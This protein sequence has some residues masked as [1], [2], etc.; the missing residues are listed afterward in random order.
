VLLLLRELLRAAPK[1]DRRHL[2]PPPLAWRLGWPLVCLLSL[3]V[4]PLMSAR[5]RHQWQQRLI[6]A[7][8]DRSIGPE[9]YL[10]GLLLFAILMASVAGLLAWW[11]QI[12]F[13]S[14]ASLLVTCSFLMGLDALRRRAALRRLAIQRRL[15]FFID[16]VT[17]SVESG[18][19]LS[20]ALSQAVERSP[21]GPLREECSRVLRDVKAGRSREDAL[22]DLAQRLDLPAVTNLVLALN[23]AQRD[24]G[25]TLRVLKAQAEQ[26]RSDRLLRAERL[27]MQAPVKLL[28]PLVVFIFPG[29]FAVL[30]YPVLS[31]LLTEVSR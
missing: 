17:M 25:G 1:Q 15:P 28:F 19:P 11:F 5:S 13:V 14:L 31:R 20:A 10:A 7:G 26:Q 23:A 4:R 18:M 8:I 2:D 16:L 12:G 29:T 9:Q 6:R 22:R 24:G 27:A 30:L 3:G 21:P